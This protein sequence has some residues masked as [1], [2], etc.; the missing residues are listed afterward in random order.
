ML[1]TLKVVKGLLCS[2]MLL[3][4]LFITLANVSWGQAIKDTKIL[5]ICSDVVSLSASANADPGSWH[6]DPGTIVLDT[7]PLHPNDNRKKIASSIPYGA[8]S[9][10]FQRTNGDQYWFHI[11]RIEPSY[12]SLSGPE[13]VCGSNQI[14]LMLSGSDNDYTYFLYKDGAQYA[15]APL[16]GTPGTGFPI[17]WDVN[18]NGSYTVLARLTAHA[19]TCFLFM[20]SEFNA[21]PSP[22]PTGYNLVTPQGD[23]YC[24]G[25]TI[26]VTLA[27]SQDRVSYQLYYEG[28]PL[29]GPRSGNTGTAITWNAGAP[30]IYSVTGTN[31]DTGCES[32]MNNTV[33]LNELESPVPFDISPRNMSYCSGSGPVAISLSGSQT[34]VEYQLRNLSGNISTPVDGSGLPLSWNVTQPGRYSV[35]ATRKDNQ[36]AALMIYYSDITEIITYSLGAD[37]GTDYCQGENGKDLRLSPASQNGVLY[38]LYKDGVLNSSKQGTGSPLIWEN[39]KKGV[40]KVV[41]SKDGVVCDMNNT[42]TLTENLYTGS[43]G[44]DAVIC[45]G[46]SVQLNAYG[47]ISYLWSPLAG[48]SNNSIPDPVASP[49]VTTV[50]DVIITNDKGCSGTE[51]VTVTVHQSPVANAG[52]DKIICQG[53]SVQL[54]A[55]GGITYQWT[56]AAGLSATDIDNPI[57]SP[58]GTTEYTVRVTNVFNCSATDKVKVTVNPSPSVNAGSDVSICRGTE[59]VLLVT[60]NADSYLWNTGATTNSITVSPL[61]T[62]TYTVTGIYAGTGCATTDNVTVTVNPLPQIFS[63][64]GGGEFCEGTAG[65]PVGLSGSQAGINYELFRDNSSTGP[66]FPG[67]GNSL[68]FGN[69]DLAG[70]YTVT[71]RNVTTNCTAPMTGDAV[72]TEKLLPGPAQSISGLKSVCPGNIVTYSIPAIDRADSYLW[73]IPAGASISGTTNT[74]SINVSYPAGSVSGNITVRGVNSCGNGTASLALIEVRPLAGATGAITGPDEVCEGT[75]NVTYSIAAVSGATSYLWQLPAGAVLYGSNIEQTEIIVNF[76]PGS[77]SGDITVTP[78]NSCG[79]GIPASIPVTVKPIPNLS[80]TPPTENFDCSVKPFIS[81]HASST[82]AIDTWLWTAH[83][84]G[85]IIAGAATPTPDVDRPGTYRVTATANGCTTKGEVVVVKVTNYPADINITKSAEIITC[86]VPLITLTATTSST[87]DVSY[88]WEASGGGNIVSG[89]GTASPVIDR[90]GF[91]KV[92]VTNTVTSCI[93]EKTIIIDDNIVKP[94]VG[95]LILK[96]SGDITCTITGVELLTDPVLPGSYS[97]FIWSTGTGIIDNPLSVTPIAGAPGIYKLTVTGSNGC[98]SEKTIE[99]FTDL[100]PPQDIFI[101]PPGTINC[102]NSQ[103]QLNGSAVPAGVTYSWTGPGIVSGINNH[104]PVVS[105]PGEYIMTVTHPVTGCTGTESVTV[106]EDKKTPL[107]SFPVLPGVITCNSPSVRIEGTTNAT[108][109]KFEWFDTGGQLIAGASTPEV[110]VTLPGTY[111]LRV[112]DQDNHCMGENTITVSSAITPPGAAIVP[113]GIISCTT[114]ELTLQ[115]TSPTAGVTWKWTTSDGHIKSGE[116]SFNPVITKE[117][118]YKL[119]VTDPLNGCISEAS[120]FVAED[121]SAP[122]IVNFTLNPENLTCNRTAVFLSGTA[123]NSSLMWSGPAGANI[124]NPSGPG[125]MVDRP[126]AYTLT[127]TGINGCIAERS[128]EVLL[129]DDTPAGAGIMLPVEPLSC[130]NLTTTL[131]GTSTTAGTSFRWET[132]DGSIISSPGHETITVNSSGTYTVFVRHPVTGC[133]LMFSETVS[134]LSEKPVITLASE[135]PEKITCNNQSSGVKLTAT[136]TPATSELLWSGPGT[137]TDNGTN[138]PTVYEPGLYTLTARHPITGCI[139]TKSIEVTANLTE[140]QILSFNS[141]GKITCGS[142]SI[143]IDPTI[144]S[145]SYGFEWTEG[146]AGANISGS[147]TNKAV[148]VTSK[149]LYIL[150]VTDLVNGC[151]VTDEIWIFD[152]LQNP[153]IF[154]DKNPAVITCKNSQTELFGT[155]TTPGVLYSWTGPGTI[156]DPNTK[157]PKVDLAGTYTLTVENPANGCKSVETVTV[158]ENRSVPPQP[159]ILTPDPITCSGSWTDLEVSPYI[160]GVDYKWTTSGT[161]TILNENSGLAS[162][163]EP[164]IYRVTVTDRLNGC[165]NFNTVEVI[166]TE[167]V[168][169]VSITGGPYFTTCSTGSLQLTGSTAGGINPQWSTIG[170]HITSDRFQMNIM[171]D[172]PGEYI[173]TVHHPVTGCPSSASVFVGQSGDVPQIDTDNF[174]DKITCGISSVRLMGRPVD[175]AHDFIWSTVEGNFAA[176][177]TTHEPWVDKPGKYI[178]TVTNPH[179]GCTNQS[180]I[181]VEEDKVPVSFTISTPAALTCLVGEIQLSSAI[182][183]G[184]TN[185]NYAWTSGPGGAIKSGD[186]FTANPVVTAKGTYT[187]TV[188]NNENQCSASREIIVNE[189]LTLP[190]VSV[191]A[192]PPLLTC[193]STQVTLSGNSLTEGAVYRWTSDDGHPVGNSNTKHPGVSNPGFYTLTVTH[194]L[195]G[196]TD[197]KK[198]EVKR[199]TVIPDIHIEPGDHTLTCNLPAVNLEGNSATG[200]V[201]YSW[202]APGGIPAGNTRIISVSQPGTYVLRVTVSSTGCF[203]ELPVTITEDKEKPAAPLVPDL[204]VCFGEPAG[205]LHATGSSIRWYK[206]SNLHPDNLLASG[207]TLTPSV[208]GI[209]DYYYYVTQRGTN[210]C[211]SPFRQVKYTVRSLPAAPSGVDQEICEGNANPQLRAHGDNISWFDTPGG[212]L[213]GT[214]AYYTPD[215]GISAAGT[216]V[217]YASQRDGFGCESGLQE[218]NFTIRPEPNAP[219]VADDIKEMCSDGLTPAFIAAGKNIKWFGSLTAIEPMALGN[220]FTPPASD[221]GTYQ[222]YLSQT[223]DFGCESERSVVTLIINDNPEKFNVTGG[224]SWCENTSG[225]PVGLSSSVFGTEYTLWLDN[226]TIVASATGTGAALDF[227]NMKTAGIYTVSAAN[228]KGCTVQMNGAVSVQENKLPLKPGLVSGRQYVCQGEANVSYEIPAVAGATSYIWEVPPGAVINTGSG[229]T[230]VGVTFS[231]AAQSGAVRVRAV[232]SCGEGPVSND[233]LITVGN[234]PA[235]AGTITATLSNTEICRG[236]EDVYFEIPAIA[237]ATSYEWILPA[238]AII[239]EGAGSRMIRARFSPESA[240]GSQTVRVRGVNDCGAGNY[241]DPHSLVVYA[242]PIVYAGDD[243]QLCSDQTTLSGSAIPAG[244]SG[245]WEITAGHGIISNTGINNPQLTSLAMGENELSYTVTLNACSVTDKVKIINNNVL[246]SA[247]DNKVLCSE[248]VILEGSLPPAGTTGLWKVT[249]GS[250]SLENATAWNTRAYNFGQGDNMLEWIITKNGCTSAATVIMTN[251]RPE[252]INAGTDI[253]TCSGEAWMDA[254]TPSAGQGEWIVLSGKASFDNVNDPKTRIFNLDKGTNTLGWKVSNQSCSVTETVKVHNKEIEITA[255]TDQVL[256]DSRTTLNATPLSGGESGE[257]SVIRGAASFVNNKQADTRVSGLMSG[258]NELRWTVK[259]D[260]CTFSE[261]KVLLINNSPTA[262]MAGPNQEVAE[263]YA[264]LEA[265]SPAIGAGRWSVISGSGTFDNPLLNTAMVTNLSPGPNILRWT[266]SN[267]GCASESDV[268]IFNGSMETLYAGEDQTLCTDQTRLNASTPAFGFGAWKVVRGSAQFEDNE[269]PN[270][271]VYGLQQGENILRWS[272]TVGGTE[273]FDDVTIINNMPTSAS[274]GADRSICLDAFTLTGNS[275]LVGAGRWTIEGGSAMITDD[276][277]HNTTVSNLAKGNNIFRWTITNENCVSSDIVVIRNDIPTTPDAGPDQTTCSGSVELYPNTPTIGNGEWS[278][279]S[280]AGLFEGNYVGQLANGENRL[281]YTIKNRQCSLS[282]EVIVTNHKPT[283]ADAGYN[284]SV[285]IDFVELTANPVNINNGE[286]G[287]WTVIN[288]SGSFDDPTVATTTVRGLAAGKNVFRWTINNMGC[289]SYDEIIISYDYIEAIAGRDIITCDSEVIL[290]ANNPGNGAGEWSVRGG[291]GSAFFENPKSPNTRVTNLDKG[292]NILRWTITSNR[293]VSYDEVNVRNSSPSDANAGPDL[294]ICENSLQLSARNPLIGTGRWTV[295]NGSGQFGN[296]EVHNTTVSSIGPGSN[297][298]RWTVVNEGCTSADEVVIRNDQP[299][300]VYAGTDQ[301]LCDDAAI[302][303]SL[304]P[305]RGVGM[306]SIEKGAGI[307]ADVFSNNTGVSGLAPDENIFR[308]TVTNGLC[309]SHAD[310]ILMNSKPSA[311]S[312]G[313]DKVICLDQAVLE[314]NIPLQGTGK[315]SVVSGSGNF[316][317]A[318]LYNTKV[319]GLSRGRNIL[320]WTISKAHCVSTDDVVIQNDMP[321]I[322]SAGTDFS[323]CDNSAPLNGNRPAVG[324]GTWTIGSGAGIFNDPLSNNTIV[325]GLGQGINI[326][327][328]TI[329]HNNC[330]L[331]DQVEIRNNQT[332]VYAGPDQI[333]FTANTN[334]SG[335]IPARGNGTWSVDAGSGSILSP[336]SPET[337]VEGLPEGANTFVWSV[338]IDGCISS[339]K[340]VVTYYRQPTASFG[341]NNS[342]GCPPLAVRFTKTTTEDYPFRWE[343]GNGI[344][345]YEENPSH[346]YNST[347]RYVSRLYVTGPDGNEVMSERIITVHE[348]PAASFELAPIELFIPGNELRTYNY[349]TNGSVYLWDFGDGNTSTEINP[350]HT[351]SNPGS[352]YVSLRVFSSEGCA[353]SLTYNLPVSVTT[354]TR[355]KFPTAFTPN[356]LGAGGGRYD[357]GDFS[358]HVFYP[359]VINGTIEN[360]LLEIFNRWGV[361]L[362]QS[363]DV[364]IGWDGY[365]RGQAASEDVYIFRVT[366]VLNNGEKFIE[367]GDFLLMRRD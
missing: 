14:T 344:S 346:T 243:Q 124:S 131:T 300:N 177:Q 17:T 230:A 34:G 259:K 271:M 110:W 343:L 193:T 137:I 116:N 130:S 352:F 222:Y 247:G 307:I 133:E 57:T 160:E 287:R 72:I 184:H 197:F 204:S 142:L 55:T 79:E 196:C 144:S 338:N 198:V 237:H 96:K 150:T 141:P 178:I 102:G 98:T 69:Q 325:S 320:R 170:G 11:T 298:Y 280:G 189:N 173:L 350:V 310:V 192:N 360:Y 232:N 357:R 93:A 50:Y 226:S 268:T 263:N 183:S 66:A 126:G 262:A 308:W 83:N 31:V 22:L 190:Q 171:V 140:P 68:S 95:S 303:S 260:G 340:V 293:C 210:G 174:P 101:S 331:T 88:Q 115:G 322:P 239:T 147:K 194:P 203:S 351:Y 244:G 269:L 207:N 256:C 186:E 274:A 149:G 270:S 89:A 205:T 67:D 38:S 107:V 208:T 214:G 168:S 163:N 312:A 23:S 35:M 292:N 172:A 349:S 267:N 265:N 227:G 159:Q 276:G 329:T 313:A 335:N 337:R 251:H 286:T 272:V 339:D 106:I 61:N 108:N 215:A 302:L 153:D 8:S 78:L 7:D 182:I 118:T 24:A 5:T 132:S 229:T 100:R 41:A 176:D 363:N 48:L 121:K 58:A 314:G 241:S 258:E 92:I 185:V 12:Y 359:V 365:Y 125:T 86:N 311:S 15:G 199:N 3:S 278:I 6:V 209:G 345:S 157:T 245:I 315:W 128:T 113:P 249:S 152:D 52:E 291:S 20:D 277:L 56:P 158:Q 29:G 355:I 367:T 4:A 306:W 356:P 316:E 18:E 77:S 218:V 9:V 10:Y 305:D 283:T 180:E 146:S 143:T 28:T 223:S 81:L 103:V 248:D 219:F 332:D 73:T 336:A 62:T 333:I 71:A 65:M 285:C 122:V 231:S 281:L 348:P 289:L 179:T 111:R 297:T 250:A 228:N 82:S 84:G 97:G 91:Y 213:L 353:D 46:E 87:F 224:G 148:A 342:E 39:M 138:N 47:G 195:S 27:S 253:S 242:P 145:G 191:D 120:V 175:P 334:L 123:A 129:V 43:A 90:K 99:V 75:L 156:T 326:L 347:G 252:N 104:N 165:T 167:S 1:K 63:V 225:V 290:N 234:L 321:T 181:I 254:S 212:I 211:E 26:P 246:V 294:A 279:I 319:T 323:I 164:G 25:L 362:F 134:V 135:L 284:M 202:T 151:K 16:S 288:G 220:E 32:P 154:I 155:S 13:F 139:E 233:L 105:L 54:N 169:A 364:E 45:Y 60:G 282:D 327:R 21:V 324:T 74:N 238:G 136:I 2:R 201:S 255:G 40:Y 216:Y 19:E 36:C 127:A 85:N 44:P 295:V 112:T 161:G 49:S 33:T 330:S 64:T 114:P 235:S 318:G 188:V 53:E 217:Y 361:L 273:Y 59:T 304:E 42:V 240:T 80:V 94:D 119:T 296:E 117:G 301:V 70:T 30:G 109:P 275:P 264:R 200:G 354:T 51:Q 236:D 309:S 261:N 317:D 366:G 162:V 266:I 221:P 166:R 341:V 328:W 257:W 206:H 187:L 358:N 76:P 299:L 37:G